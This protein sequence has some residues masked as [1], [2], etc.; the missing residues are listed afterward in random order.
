MAAVPGASTS[1]STTA[2]A[3][4]ARSSGSGVP[5]QAQ[6]QNGLLEFAQCM[7]AS[8][9]PNFPDP[10]AGGGFLLRTG[11]GIDPSSPVFKAAQAKCQK[12]VPGGL[13]PGPGATTNPSAQALAHWVTVAQCMR[14][15]G[16]PG[17]PDPRTSV[18][19]NP[20]GGAVGVIS[21]RDGVILVFPATIDMQSLLFT[22]AAAACG[23]QLTN[24]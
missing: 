11:A 6:F 4:R 1:G 19:S 3:D 5:T 15:H 13:P 9:V 18:P 8:G 21:D 17:F 12:L 20:A 16:I 2:A 10:G 7:R 24:N 22:R 14:R 23:F